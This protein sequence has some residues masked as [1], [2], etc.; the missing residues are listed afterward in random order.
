MVVIL[1]YFMFQEIPDGCD[2]IGGLIIVGSGA[3]IAWRDAK[4]TKLARVVPAPGP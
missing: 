1:A 3:Y 4:L 2:I